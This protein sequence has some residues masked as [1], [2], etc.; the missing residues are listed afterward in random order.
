MHITRLEITNEKGIGKIVVPSYYLDLDSWDL[1]ESG[2]AIYFF[3][4]DMRD[5]LVTD[6]R[7]VYLNLQMSYL[8]KACNPKIEESVIDSL[9]EN[10]EDEY[11][12]ISNKDADKLEIRLKTDRSIASQVGH[13]VEHFLWQILLDAQKS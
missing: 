6:Y 4:K 11:W 3:E 12:I 10:R 8:V 2:K 9:L 7:K 13:H 1:Y 5:F